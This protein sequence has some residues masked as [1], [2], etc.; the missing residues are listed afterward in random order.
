MSPVVQISS[1]WANFVFSLGVF[2]NWSGLKIVAG[3][4][5]I[6]DVHFCENSDYCG[7]GY[8]CVNNRC[9]KECEDS[10][11]PL[12]VGILVILAFCLC[13]C[14][15][16]FLI[17]YLVKKGNSVHD[18]SS[19][20]TNDQ[21]QSD[22]ISTP[23]NRPP[24]VLSIIALT[25][26]LTMT[27][28]NS[29]TASTTSENLHVRKPTYRMGWVLTNENAANFPTNQNARRASEPIATSENFGATINARSARNSVGGYNL[30][31]YNQV[32]ASSGYGGNSPPP[33]SYQEA[34]VVDGYDAPPS[35]YQ[36][37]DETNSE[38]NQSNQNLESTQNDSQ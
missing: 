5:D 22:Q 36:T 27:N 37:D 19:G 12:F 24:Y 17:R 38:A 21:N 32:G 6:P 31:S 4:S 13:S 8:C 9:S 3:S 15:L 26:G 30:P 11:V 14:A 25:H 34:V 35:Y 1:L 18:A 2:I 20:T 10:V 23:E 28:Q 29:P 16:I 33:P 7:S